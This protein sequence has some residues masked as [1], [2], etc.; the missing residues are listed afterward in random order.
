MLPIKA[1]IIPRLLHSN[2]FSHII[3]DLL[4]EPVPVPPAVCSP[5]P[6]ACPGLLRVVRAL[7]GGL[8]RI[9]LAAGVLR[10]E[11]ADAVAWA[12]QRYA[13]GV[14]EATNRANLQIRGIGD[15]AAELAEHLL[16]A[17]L[18]PRSAG[19]DDVRN[20]MLSPTAGIDPAQT[21][22]VGP[23]AAQILASLESR[24]QLH[25]LSA[26]FALQLDGGEALAMLEHHH[27]LWLSALTVEGKMFLALGLAGSPADGS[28]VA[29]KLEDGHALVMAVLERFLQLAT[30]G[31]SRMRELAVA[32]QGVRALLDGSGPPLH[33]VAFQR[34]VQAVQALGIHH[35]RQAGLVRVG[36]APPLGRLHPAMLQGLAEASRRWGNGT[37]RLTPWQGL[38]LPDVPVADAAAVLSHLRSLGLLTDPQQPLAQSVAC[39]G[40][41]GCVKAR[42]DT[43]ADARRLAQLLPQAGPVHLS[44][45]ER[46]C[47]A[48]HTAPVTL[49]AVA[50]GHYDLYFRDAAGR[51]FGTLQARNLSLDAAADWLGRS[52]SDTHD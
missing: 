36:A 19:A 50:P 30:P 29:V 47:A 49:L 13:S 1:G 41:A 27:D 51:G 40:S 2:V 26:K 17:G 35:Q 15:G 21:L 5:R 3:G 28:D 16:D 22:D 12:A 32:G 44:G 33:T 43:K 7:D 39:T 4:N 31:Q 6:S 37:L 20:L 46:S 14:I 34:P 10:A 52:R 18:G 25:Q 23:L 9:K 8:C 45:C 42:A 48:A 24:P 38:L 11:Q